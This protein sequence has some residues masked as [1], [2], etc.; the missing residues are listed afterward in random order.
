M[1]P[2]LQPTATL[3]LQARSADGRACESLVRQFM[4]PAYVVALSIVQR[5]ADA[6]D[7]AQES[8]MVAFEKLDSCRDPACFP[9]WLMQIV[10]NRARNWLDKR[11]LRDVAS[12]DD[13]PAELSIA[14]GETG[15]QKGLLAALSQLTGPQRE[16]VLLHDLE[17][18]THAEI[19]STLGISE[20][21]SRQHLFNAR[22]RVRAYLDPAHA[23]KVN[24]GE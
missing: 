20:L 8:L 19:A 10:R 4:R 7:I 14:P 3:V 6:E 16:V 18:W 13:A 22:Q 12:E 9:A 15:M 21:M 1:D 23:P 24:H 11:R 2:A 5:P 17:E